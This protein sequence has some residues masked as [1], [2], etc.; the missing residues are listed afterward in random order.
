MGLDEMIILPL[1]EGLKKLN[2]ETFHY[3]THTISPFFLLAFG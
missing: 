3:D 1:A 2:Q